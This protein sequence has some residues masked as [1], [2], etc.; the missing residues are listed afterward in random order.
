MSIEYK[1][2]ETGYLKFILLYWLTNQ[3]LLIDWD[4]YWVVTLIK[5]DIW[6]SCYDI[7]EPSST[8]QLS[9]LSDDIG[10]L[11]FVLWDALKNFMF[12]VKYFHPLWC[13][14]NSDEATRTVHDR[15]IARLMEMGFTADQASNALM[16]NNGDLLLAV[17]Y[18][19]GNPASCMG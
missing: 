5:L 4:V 3:V 13:F 12:W 2:D 15:N 9:F 18:L 1:T 14:S 7:N 11:E 16:L 19:M 10:Y 8:Y 17:N 6:N